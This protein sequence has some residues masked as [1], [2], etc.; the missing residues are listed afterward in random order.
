MYSLYL[1]SPVEGHKV[2]AGTKLIILFT[3]LF[4]EPDGSITPA[5]CGTMFLNNSNLAVLRHNLDEHDAT[6]NRQ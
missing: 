5:A 3:D 6:P 2:V 4:P 1:S